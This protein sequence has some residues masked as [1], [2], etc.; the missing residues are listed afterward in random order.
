MEIH[1]VQIYLGIKL[2][3][4][5]LIEYSLADKNTW[6]KH[7]EIV[8]RVYHWLG[9]LVDVCDGNSYFI[10]LFRNT[11][12][13][14]KQWILKAPSLAGKNTFIVSVGKWVE[15]NKI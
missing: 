13:Q 8:I 1:I 5:T 3:K 4:R 12:N 2:I 7:I 10:D 11:V 6:I 15:K 14:N 9:F